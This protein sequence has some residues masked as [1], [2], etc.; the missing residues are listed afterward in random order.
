MRWLVPVAA[1]CASLYT[2][3]GCVFEPDVK[4]V[5]ACG[6]DVLSTGY[7]ILGTQDG[8]AY[9]LEFTA[10]TR[11]EPEMGP[12][13]F[14][15]M[16]TAQRFVGSQ[17]EEVREY[18]AGVRA[19]SSM[20]DQV[21]PSYPYAVVGSYFGW[22]EPEV[23]GGSALGDGWFGVGIEGGFGARLGLGPA[24]LDLEVIMSYGVFESWNNLTSIR[25]G[26]ALAV[27]W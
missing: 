21:T 25:W 23:G 8:Q 6:Y 18:R 3:T 5:R 27:E 26:G 19:L 17:D 9:T 2:G 24:A 13:F 16:F 12:L 20:L 4:N 11:S 14:G 7:D 10:G 22:Y 15:A 1:C